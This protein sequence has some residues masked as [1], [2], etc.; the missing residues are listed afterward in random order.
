MDAVVPIVTSSRLGTSAGGSG[1]GALRR[2]SRIH[3]PRK[4]GD[5]R[6]AYDETVRTL[7]WVTMP[8]RGE[9]VEIDA[10]E[11]GAGHAGQAVVPRQP[12]VDERVSRVDEVEHAPVVADDVLEEAFRLLLHRQPQ[13]VLEVR[14]P[15]AIPRHRFERAELQPLAAKVFRERVRLRI[16]QHAAH[17]GRE[18]EGIA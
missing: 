18:H 15:V 2:L 5:V 13:V 11:L 14:E 17:L 12:F 6:V 1:G 8:P 16:A 9:P 4:T 10:A 3:L 7:A